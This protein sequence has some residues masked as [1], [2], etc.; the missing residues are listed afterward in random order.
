[1]RIRFT[2]ALFFLAKQGDL[3]DAVGAG[4]DFPAFGRLFCPNPLPD[5]N[6][7]FGATFENLPYFSAM[8]KFGLSPLTWTAQNFT[9]LEDLCSVR[10]NPRSNMGGRVSTL[11]ISK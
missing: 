11:S 10:G 9:D 7:V 2:A 1:M 4:L 6:W 8:A 5:P 3:V